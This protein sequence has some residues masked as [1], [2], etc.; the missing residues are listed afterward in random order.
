M[1]EE[2]TKAFMDRS[3]EK[4]VIAEVVDTVFDFKPFFK[5]ESHDMQNISF[6]HW[7][8]LFMGAD[9]RVA[10]VSGEW[11]PEDEHVDLLSEKTHRVF[12]VNID[13]FFS[14]YLYRK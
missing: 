3:K 2:P 9:G 8:K 6:V 1:L 10:L 5:R 12:L 4:I 7:I 11:V 13:C 14:R